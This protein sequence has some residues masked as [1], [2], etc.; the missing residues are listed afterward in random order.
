MVQPLK[1]GRELSISSPLDNIN[2]LMAYLLLRISRTFF[3][4]FLFFS[5]IEYIVESETPTKT[6]TPPITDRNVGI[7]PSQIHEITIASAGVRYKELVASEAPCF[8]V[9]YAIAK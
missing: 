3:I 8:D 5:F 6:T 9:A 2:N 1:K 7:S 4:F